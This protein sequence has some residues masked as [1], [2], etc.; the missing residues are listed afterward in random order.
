MSR[1]IVPH[2]IWGC[3]VFLF[4]ISSSA[5]NP[6]DTVILQLKWRHQFQFAGF[7]AAVEKGFY[8]EAGLEVVIREGIS[9]MD[10]VNEVVQGKVQFGIESPKLVIDRNSG[11]PVVALAA[12]FQHSPEVL[13]T[14]KET[15]ITGPAD[16]SSHRISIGHHGMASTMAI[17]L[18]NNINISNLIID[19]QDRH[20]QSLLN[21]D[22][23]LIDSYITDAP[24]II[25]QNGKTPVLFRPITYGID[26]YGDVLF[27]SQA[28]IEKHLG[29]VQNFTEASSKGWIYAM[30]NKEEIVDLIHD[31]YSTRVPKDQLLYEASAMEELL[32]PKLIRP[33]HMNKDRW[34]HIADTYV[35]LG[36]L[37]QNYSLNGFLVTDYAEAEG[38]RMKLLFRILEIL[39]LALITIS[40]ITFTFNRKL[41]KAVASRTDELSRINQ[42]LLVEISER[43]RILHS[44][45]LSEERF[46]RL[47]EDAPIS[48]WEEDFS[49]VKQILDQ[50]KDKGIDDF[51]SYF[52][53]HP[54]T[55]E[56]CIKGIKII[57][58]NQ[59]TVNYFEADSKKEVIDNVDNIFMNEASS[60]LEEEIVAFSEGKTWHQ[61]ESSHHTLRG[62]RIYVSI[63]VKIPVGFEDSWKKVLVSLINITELKEASN[64]LMEK[65]VI[66]REQN[67]TLRD[68]NQ[69][70]KAINAELSI[71]KRKAE[72]SDYLKTA[73]LSNMSHEIRTPMMGII[74]FIDLLK[75]SEP[76]DEEFIKY[77]N[78]IED[79]SHQLLR[80]ISDII[81]ISKIE[82]GQLSIKKQAIDVSKIVESVREVFNLKL[83][84]HTEKKISLEV[85][86]DE[87]FPEPLLLETDETRLRQ[88]LTNLVEN[89]I[90]FTNQ[91][92]V[93]IG[94]KKH[95]SG[96]LFFVQDT[97]K[98]IQEE[99][100]PMIFDRFFKEDD[101]F[102]TNPG[103]T[104]LGLSIAKSLVDLLGGQIWV[105]S[106]PA[107]GSTF[108]FTHPL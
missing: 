70:I 31:K 58:I 44:L 36:L 95:V 59:V 46:K 51:T 8:K 41:R 42:N 62:N 9:D 82:A 105:E 13:V 108:F 102:G 104:G 47:F 19:Q 29:L 76:N 64:Q 48:L 23:E 107:K 40:L 25:R 28:F 1:K 60:I 5:V 14:T 84:V 38:K 45:S 89:A 2:L 6:P 87:Q 66:L 37:D 49:E 106:E 96:L 12:I 98:G 22:V 92:T 80:I 91:G 57:N 101:Q 100:L 30:N 54:D 50:L 16:F 93:S 56:E 103:G 68:R 55:L 21:G 81:D 72:E 90:K 63:N 34:K 67:E 86:I 43:K 65:E 83:K 11:K 18:Q 97:G 71:A 10:F 3:L 85:L 78:I 17:F 74:G 15:G 79:N 20:I 24:Y 73:F 7:Y 77:L 35:D 4:T 94:I 61:A 53:E 27:T 26:F 69:K 33:G 39:V 75:M 88:I 99:R 52:K 32:L